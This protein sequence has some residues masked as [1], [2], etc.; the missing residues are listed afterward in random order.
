MYEE[1]VNFKNSGKNPLHEVLEFPFKDLL[2]QSSVTERSLN[3]MFTMLL[4][5]HET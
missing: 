2:S 1:D 5:R 4:N 3:P